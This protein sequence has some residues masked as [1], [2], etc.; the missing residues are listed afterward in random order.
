M[1]PCSRSVDDL[2]TARLYCK[3]PPSVLY[4]SNFRNLGWNFAE[5]AFGSIPMP[6]HNTNQQ[7]TS[8]NMFDDFLRNVF[9]TVWSIHVE[10]LCLSWQSSLILVTLMTLFCI[11]E[12]MRKWKFLTFWSNQRVIR[13]VSC[14][15][16][17]YIAFVLNRITVMVFKSLKKPAWLKLKHVVDL[18]QHEVILSSFIDKK[19]I[20][21]SKLCLL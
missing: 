16:K 4:N 1:F 8:L 13:L 6:H 10:K 19:N 9:R 17:L 15:S 12:I 2:L 5:N 3:R 7:W 14:N 20:L 21:L 11:A 18:L